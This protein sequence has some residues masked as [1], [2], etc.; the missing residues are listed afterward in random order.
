VEQ[1]L[2]HFKKLNLGGRFRHL[3][4]H[5]LYI[6][7]RF[8][9]NY[10]VHL[11]EVEGFYTEVWMRTDLDQVCWIEVADIAKVAENYAASIDVKSE[12]GL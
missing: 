12:L 5:G 1:K 3:R 6:D 4:D 2:R 9:G 11:Y 8:F 10:R 7:S